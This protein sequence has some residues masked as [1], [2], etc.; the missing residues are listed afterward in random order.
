MVFAENIPPTSRIPAFSVNSNQFHSRFS[1]VCVKPEQPCK[2][3]TKGLAGL[4][5]QKACKA[6]AAFVARLF[7][8]QITV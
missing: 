8:V 7:S 6:F 1:I 5:S 2:P 3:V 4:L